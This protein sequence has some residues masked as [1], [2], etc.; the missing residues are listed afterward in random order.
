MPDPFNT[1][2]ENGTIL[3]FLW[4]CQKSADHKAAPI[5]LFC[6]YND[7]ERPC[8]ETGKYTGY[9]LWQSKIFWNHISQ[10]DSDHKS[11]YDYGGPFYIVP[12]DQSRNEYRKFGHPSSLVQIPSS[13]F[14]TFGLVIEP[15]HMEIYQSELIHLVIPAFWN[16]C[17]NLNV[18]SNAG[19]EYRKLR[20]DSYEDY[21]K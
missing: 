15:F 7:P 21:F 13:D 9:W 4:D 6:V 12:V 20:L 14:K 8:T 1:T 3:T 16:S 5:A 2:F 19:F 10:A 18:G 17:P 11:F